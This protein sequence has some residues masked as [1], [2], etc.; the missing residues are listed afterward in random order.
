[1]AGFLLFLLIV[2]GVILI[3][4][5]LLSRNKDSGA[6][7]LDNDI[8]TVS[9]LQVALLAAAREIQSELTQ[10]SADADLDSPEGRVELLRE[11]ALALL[12]KPE[13]WTHARSES[14]TVKSREE[15]GQLFEEMSIAERRK[16]ETETFSNVEG[17]I[18]QRQ[19]DADPDMELPAY[20]VVTLL[21]GT[22]DDKPLFES[23]YSAE[24]VQQALERV[25]S[26]TPEYLAVFE[27]LW[28]PQNEADSLSDD[29]LLMEYADMVHIG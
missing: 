20:I 12:R 6:S 28:S 15:A 3:A 9:K 24:D 13:Y 14:K 10:M 22:E 1:M 26:V 2:G 8:V 19:A 7:E 18:R 29:E 4:W 17:R 5:W 11:S 23:V 21:V 27:L 16:F 25:A